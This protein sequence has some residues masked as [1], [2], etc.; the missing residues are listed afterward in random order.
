[1]FYKIIVIIILVLLF[2]RL[3]CY[4]LFWLAIKILHK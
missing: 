3:V 1:M 4:G 2:L